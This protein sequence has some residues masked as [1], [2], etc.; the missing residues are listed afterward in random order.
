MEDIG[1]VVQ[2]T[3]LDYFFRAV[4]YPRYRAHYERDVALTVVERSFV[5]D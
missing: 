5:N 4:R 3:H 1:S 2:A